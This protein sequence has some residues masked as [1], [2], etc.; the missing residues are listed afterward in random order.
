M[1]EEFLLWLWYNNWFC[2]FTKIYFLVHKSLLQ[3]LKGFWRIH[4]P[5]LFMLSVAD[6]SFHFSF[7]ISFGSVYLTG[8]P[9]SIALEYYHHHHL[10][11]L[12]DCKVALYFLENSVTSFASANR[13]CHVSTWLAT[14]YSVIYSSNRTCHIYLH[15]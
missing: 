7:V 15:I 8:L 6:D 14:S 2:P 3:N 9:F 12:C 11:L 10:Y 4:L 1:V 5:A 13:S